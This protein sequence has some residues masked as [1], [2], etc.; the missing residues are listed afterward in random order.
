MSA[1]ILHQ[2]TTL[3]EGHFPPR[4][5]VSPALHLLSQKETQAEAPVSLDQLKTESSH[6][7]WNF[8]LPRAS[9]QLFEDAGLKPKQDKS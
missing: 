7:S 9:H 4:M 1:K 6:L 5:T 2:I 3:P 8:C